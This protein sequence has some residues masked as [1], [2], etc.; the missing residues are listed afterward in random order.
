MKD[1]GLIHIYCGDGKGKTTAAMGLGVR[2]AGHGNHV[3]IVQFLKSRPTGEL[4]SLALLPSVEVMRGKETKK[5]TF[6]M[7][8]EE[9][10]RYEKVL[11]VNYP[12]YFKEIEIL[13]NKYKDRIIIKKGLEFGIQTHTVEKFRNLFNSYD[14]DF[15]ILSCH[16][17]DNKE[18]WN[19]AYQEG[20]T[21]D[22][23]NLG[24]YQEIYS[25]IHQYN[26]YSVLGHLD[27]IQ[28]YNKKRYP[29]EKSK[30]I[31]T[32]ILKKVIKENK[33]I[34]VNTSS[35]AY[36]LEDLT[37]S[38]DIL[39]LYYELGGKIITIGSDAHNAKSVGSHIA[40][41]QQELKNIGFRYFCTFDKMKPVFHEL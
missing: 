19:Y 7:N 13:K 32:E 27:L 39:S 4:A 40:L 1:G 28:R 26:D 24:Y 12:D 41:I 16:Q 34:E 23:Y 22:E 3:L 6:Q 31:I 5:F 9:K 15:I 11:N 36:K 21:E 10:V 33:G 30:D 37:P 17:S 38:R 8:D 20:K 2:C 18:F 25:C 14:L 35:F 29:F